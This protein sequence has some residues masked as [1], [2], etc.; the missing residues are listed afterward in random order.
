VGNVS[1]FE[2]ARLALARLRVGGNDE[3]RRGLLQ[4]AQASAHALDVRRVGI[5]FFDEPAAQLVCFASWDAEEGASPGGASLELGAVPGYVE[6]LR[7]RRVILAHDALAAPETR[8]LRDAY[9]VPNGVT[10]L[11]DAPI[12]RE[13]EV[14]GVACH[15]HCGP[16]RTWTDR[17]RDLAASLADVVAVMLEQASRLDGEA[18]LRK[19]QER[20]ARLE[21]VASL[22][23]LAAGV[24]HDFNNVLGAL[25]LQ[26]AMIRSIDEERLAGPVADALESAKAGRDLVGQLL[27]YARAAAAPEPGAPSTAKPVHLNHV[28]RERRALLEASLGPSHSLGLELP[29]LPAV[30]SIDPVAVDQ[31]VLNLLLNA[32]EAMPEGGKVEL[33]LRAG[34][35]ASTLSVV[36]R[37]T[38]IDAAVK[39]R[40]FDPFFS[41]KN[42]GTRL[43]LSTVQALVTQAGGEVLVDSRP[44][45]GTTVTVKLPRLEAP[46]PAT[47]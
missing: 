18:E 7:S 1:E 14:V 41:T 27:A 10:S 25:Q 44:G 43:G 24:A 31:I 20:M 9:L 33:V 28:L 5:W 8:E 34:R 15:E 22:A 3:L 46:S 39:G 6:A 12:F 4:A 19:Q 42:R 13:G 29:E 21:R 40:I 47:S 45:V 30:V 32:K 16:A 37:G 38:G 11:L 17:E 26:L 2:A 23:Q 36:D 35:K